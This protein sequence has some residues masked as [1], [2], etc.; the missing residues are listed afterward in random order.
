MDRIVRDGNIVHFENTQD[1]EPEQ[2]HICIHCQLAAL[3]QSNE[4]LACEVWELKNEVGRLLK[5]ITG[6]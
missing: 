2:E 3:T 6:K 4:D 5:L 1:N